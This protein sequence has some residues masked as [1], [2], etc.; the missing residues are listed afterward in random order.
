MA[1]HRQIRHVAA[2][3]QSVPPEFAPHRAA[4]LHQRAADYTVA[5]VRLG[6]LERVYDAAIL[7]ALTLLGGLQFIDLW[8][9][10]LTQHDFL[11]QLLLLACVPLLLGLL[12]LPFTLWRQFRLEGA[13][14][15]T[16]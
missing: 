16:A 4:Q 3:R 6:M 10:Q 1:G 2:N 9:G 12:G 11:R 13:S 8:L 15:S 7:V 14:A 5:R